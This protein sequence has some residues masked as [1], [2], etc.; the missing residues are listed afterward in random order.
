MT[1]PSSAPRQKPKLPVQQ[2]SILAIARFCEPVALM[3]IF[4]YLPEMIESFGVPRNEIAKWAGIITGTFAISQSLTAVWWG[5]ASDRWGRK[6]AIIAGLVFSMVCFIVWGFA[7]NLTAAIVVRF[8]QGAGN[9]NVGIIRT[10]VAEMVT[11][12]E[13]QPRAFSIMPLV[14]SVGSIFGPAFGGFFAKPAQRFPGLF[15]HSQ[16]LID[17]PFAL[18]NLIA[19]AFFLVSIA[20]AVLFLKETLDQKRH[21]DDWGILIGKRLTR[22]LRISRAPRRASFVDGEATAPL[23]P[24]KVSARRPR[25]KAASA[26][27]PAADVRQCFTPQ[28]S[29]A[30]IAYMGL[31]LHSMAYDQIIPVFL[32]LPV[33]D[34]AGPDTSL[35][36][37][38][39]GGFGWDSGRIGSVFTAYGLTCS[40]VQFIIFP[41]LCNYVG[42][43]NCFRGCVFVMPVAY[44][45]TPFTILIADPVMRTAALLAVMSLKAFGIILAFPCVIILMTNSASSVHILGTLNGVATTVSAVGRATGPAVTGWI[46]TRG[47]E[48]GYSIAPW[49]F[50]SLVAAI[51]I[52]PS[53][54][55]EDGKGPAALSDDESDEDD[56]NAIEEED[57][58]PYDQPTSRTPLL[59]S[60]AAGASYSGTATATSTTNASSSQSQQS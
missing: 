60:G 9:G 3:S 40:L 16:F 31:A 11:E 5:Q 2:L 18:P 25:R 52:I 38:F 20:T 17:Y 43:R 28:S 45:L 56:E 41:P 49:W 59:S 50:L 27:A 23:I 42:V 15:G 30:L 33:K 47:L 34:H 10:M 4:P 57:L 1:Q 13:L 22:A 44:F 8:I 51:S 46:F 36:F 12:K 6:P 58:E 14:W 26:A 54:M 21:L 53:W 48:S 35:P 7:S 24:S 32:N 39:T 55:L 37:K 29:I 19:A